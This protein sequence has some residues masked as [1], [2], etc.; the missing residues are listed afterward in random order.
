MN[1]KI[2][3]KNILFIKLDRL[4]LDKYLIEVKLRDKIYIDIRKYKVLFTYK[5]YR[6]L[7]SLPVHGQRTKTNANTNKKKK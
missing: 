4:I 2:F 1:N 7:Y 3:F 5:G 6:H